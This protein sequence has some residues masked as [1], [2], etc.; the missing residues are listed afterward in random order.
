MFFNEEKFRQRAAE[1]E[2]RRWAQKSSVAV[3]YT[4]LSVKWNRDEDG[5]MQV[6]SWEAGSEK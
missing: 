6:D 4:H 5:R 1:L 3:S 2:G